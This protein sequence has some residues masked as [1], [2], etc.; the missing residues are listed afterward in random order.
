MATPS[1]TRAR[2][3]DARKAYQD[4]GP[5]IGSRTEVEVASGPGVRRGDRVIRLWRLADSWGVSGRFGPPE[6]LTWQGTCG[7]PVCQ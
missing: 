6:C 1:C 7:Q 2:T 4:G 5:V 3:K